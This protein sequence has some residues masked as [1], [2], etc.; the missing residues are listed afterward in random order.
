MGLL[1]T[2]SRTIIAVDILFALLLAFS[3]GYIEPG[4]SSYVVAQL[5]LAPI[6]LTF[7]AGVL[8]LYTGWD[9]LD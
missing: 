9:P 6:V 5:T 8:I 1:Q 3:F 2:A 4:T 7:V